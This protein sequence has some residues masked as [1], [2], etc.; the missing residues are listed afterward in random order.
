MAIT[1]NSKSIRMQVEGIYDNVK[2]SGEISVDQENSINDI[3][4]SIFIEDTYIGS[5]YI[6][7][8][9]SISIDD[10]VNLSHLPE[11]AAKLPEFI[12]EILT[13]LS[14]EQ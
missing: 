7:S 4:G 8:N 5:F 10:K 1:I 12:E 2:L 13:Q 14:N 9:A 3:N 6:S 11:V